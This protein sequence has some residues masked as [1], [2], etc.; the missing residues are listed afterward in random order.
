MSNIGHHTPAD[1]HSEYR[2]QAA[3]HF[4]GGTP[5]RRGGTP[6]PIDRWNMGRDVVAAALLL[7][8]LLLPW[9]LGFGVGVPDSNGWIFALLVVATI[10]SWAALALTFSARR[11]PRAPE[12]TDRIRLGLNAPYL[13]LVLGFVAVAVVQAVRYG[14]TGEAGPGIGPGAMAGTAGALLSAQPLLSGDGHDARLRGWQA[15]PRV[16]GVVAIVLAVLSVLFNLYWRTRFVLPNI[17]DAEFGGQ[18][19]AV[20]ATAVVYGVVALFGVLI[21]LSWLLQGRPAAHLATVALGGSAL[22]ASTAVWISDIGRD[23][24]AFHGIA[25]TTSTA[26]VGFEGYLTWAAAA[27]I[28]GPLA[29]RN[30]CTTKPFDKVPW[31]DAARKC[32][33]LIAFWCTGSALLRIFDLIVAASLGLPYSPY[34][35]IALLAFDV[36]AAVVAF[37]LRFNLTSGALRSSVLTALSGVLFVLTVCRVVVGV[38][39][40]PRILYT[41]A[42]TDNAVYGNDLAQ[43]ITST[44]DVVLCVLALAV[45][46][47]AVVVG[48]L[49]GV[50]RRRPA[51]PAAPPRP[52]APP[53]P[54]PPAPAPPAMSSGA[55]WAKP[56]ARRPTEPATEQLTRPVPR[57]R[58]RIAGGESTQRIEAAESAPTQG[59]RTEPPK[60][61]PIAED[62]TQRFASGPSSSKQE[63]SAGEEPDQ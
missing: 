31:W 53:S 27:A 44:F 41:T 22:V 6:A 20:V 30:A 50:M 26:A 4:G 60:I 45:V 9:N 61:A 62:S 23:V 15:V 32:L 56:A 35:S 54:P 51:T 13:L 63:P 59:L 47:V 38:G 52:P 5:G 7:L 39:L 8:A 42:P 17:G 57:G 36:V 16:I 14:G 55:E 11:G 25:Q 21:G 10:L 24:D 28:L 40:A 19:L 34:D 18:N 33:L 12:A 1:A 3:Q 46:A 48:Q 43:Q 2:R 58:P 29:L 37:W 49:V